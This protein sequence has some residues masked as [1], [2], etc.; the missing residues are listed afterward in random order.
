QRTNRIMEEVNQIAEATPGVQSVIAISGISVLDNSA[1]LANAGVAYVVLKDWAVRAGIPGAD[2]LSLYKGLTASLE[3]VQGA[4][5]FVL[6]PPPIQGIG[7]AS[8]FTMQTEIRNG[9]FDY[10]MLEKITRAIVER[11]SSQ[12][13][14][15]RLNS[16][17]RAGVPQLAVAVDRIKAEQLGIT[18]GQ[19]FST[20]SGS[21]GSSYIKQ[22]NKFGRGFPVYAHA[23]PPY[24][25]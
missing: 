21:I 1:T 16:S 22:F 5:T 23:V 20:L 3:K 6:V 7:N 12:S 2:L 13:A 24:P 8:G 4:T 10:A 19:V 11:G 9:N 17:F 14:L 18:V 25:I 15:Q